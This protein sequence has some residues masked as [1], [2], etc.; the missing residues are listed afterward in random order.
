MQFRTQRER[1]RVILDLFID[2]SFAL[3]RVLLTRNWV[4]RQRRHKHQLLLNLLK[5]LKNN[6]GQR[7]VIRV[8]RRRA[9]NTV[10]NLRRR[11]HAA[12]LRNHTLDRRRK[13]RRRS[14]QKHTVCL[15]VW[16]ERGIGLC[17]EWERWD[18]HTESRSVYIYRW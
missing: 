5:R 12:D 11:K 15:C 4:L 1:E 2:N 3:I 17:G 10:P 14:S 8:L 6:A 13:N 16:N 9:Y 7:P 18:I